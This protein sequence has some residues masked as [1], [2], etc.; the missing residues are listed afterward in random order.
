[1]VLLAADSILYRGHSIH[2][3]RAGCQLFVFIAF[4]INS[5]QVLVRTTTQMPLNAHNSVSMGQF[6]TSSR[7]LRLFSLAD[8]IIIIP[9]EHR[10]RR[11]RYIRVMLLDVPLQV[12]RLVGVY[13]LQAH[14]AGRNLLGNAREEERGAQ[15]RQNLHLV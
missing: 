9:H 14:G 6:K 2:V 4:L 7:T 3:L 8:V 10:R 13:R 12:R 15:I 1:L 5:F 11:R